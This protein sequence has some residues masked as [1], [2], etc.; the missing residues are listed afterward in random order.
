M[1]VPVAE[2]GSDWDKLRI[3]S[4]GATAADSF[5]HA[6]GA[7]G[8]GQPAANRRV[9]GLEQELKVSL[10]HRYARGLVL[11]GQ[12]EHL[13]RPAVENGIGTGVLPD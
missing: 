5:A 1:R 12:G 13:L 4:V 7:R 10:F 11:T 8:L 2:R 9:S 6:G 3:F